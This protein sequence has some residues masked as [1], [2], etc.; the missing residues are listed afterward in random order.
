MNMCSPTFH[1]PHLESTR[2]ITQPDRQTFFISSN[3]DCRVTYSNKSKIK[4]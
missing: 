4:T 3:G 1:I 2:E